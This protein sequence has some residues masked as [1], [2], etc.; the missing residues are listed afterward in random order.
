MTET[1]TAH[2]GEE[3]WDTFLSGSLPIAKNSFERLAAKPLKA[4]ATWASACWLAR[5]MTAT[6]TISR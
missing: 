4:P 2:G 1:F 3:F 5:G 6:K